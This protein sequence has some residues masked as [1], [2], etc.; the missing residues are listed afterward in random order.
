FRC[1]QCLGRPVLCGPCLVHSHRH[2]P[3]HWPEQWV[4][5]SHTSSK[6]WEQLLGVDIWP[7]TQ[8]RPKT[9]FTMEVLR[10]QRCFNLQSK[11]NLKEYYDAL[12]RRTKLTDLPFPM[13]Y[14]YDQFRIAVREYRALVTHM[15]AG[16]LDATA[17]L[18]NG[19]LCVV[20]PACPHPGV[21]LPHNWEKDPL[22]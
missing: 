1:T 7:A 18:A 17:P 21:N 11:T 13:Q 6:L 22:K 14:I 10:H 3:F 2:S 4:D 8:K 19:E 15:R 16:R 20:C 9:G 5:Q 12:S